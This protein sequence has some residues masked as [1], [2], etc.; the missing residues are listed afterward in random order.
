VGIV[1]GAGQGLITV[2][3]TTVALAT[4]APEHRAEGS[5]VFNL[6][7]SMGSSVGVSIVNS[8]LTYYVQVNHADISTGV[9]AFNRQLAAPNVALFWSPLTAG[10]RAGLDA[11]INQQAQV[12]AYNNDY[13]FLMYATLATLPLLLMLR[14]P[15]ETAAES[16]VPAQ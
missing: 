4:I 2:P 13:K 14:K 7:R 5:G 15:G 6:A 9:T 16:S 10:G 11:V 1:Q 12:I 3:L 8:M